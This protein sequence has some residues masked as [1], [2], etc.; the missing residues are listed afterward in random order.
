MKVLAL[1]VVLLVLSGCTSILSNDYVVKAFMCTQDDEAS[2]LKQDDRIETARFFGRKLEAKR[3]VGPGWKLNF[4][5]WDTWENAL[6]GTVAVSPS[7]H[8]GKPECFKIRPIRVEGKHGIE[9]IMRTLQEGETCDHTWITPD[10]INKV[11]APGLSC[12]AGH[13]G[14]WVA[15]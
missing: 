7:A 14:G 8:E 4:E 3:G 5:G 12:P 1:T 15:Y 9:I 13:T 11:R 10:F 6:Y 2:H